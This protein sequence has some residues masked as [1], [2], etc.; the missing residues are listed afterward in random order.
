MCSSPFPARKSWWSRRV[1]YAAHMLVYTLST[2][3][4][5]RPL[6]KIASMSLL[7]QHGAPRVHKLYMG[8]D[9]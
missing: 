4:Q 1:W 3:L 9:S 2:K 7:E 6:D 8:T 5:T